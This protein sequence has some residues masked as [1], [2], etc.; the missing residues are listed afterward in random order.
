[1]LRNAIESMMA[2]SLLAVPSLPTE[3]A[4]EARPDPIENARLFG[5]HQLQGDLMHTQ[6]IDLDERR[7]W[8]TSVDSRNS[9]GYLQ[10][11]DRASGKLLRRLDLTDGAR[12][13]PG[14]FS[15]SGNSIWVPVAEYSA[16]TSSVIVEV[17]I[18][19]LTIRR[20]ITIAD[21]LGCAAVTGDTLVAGNWD[22]KQLYVID[23]RGTASP[24]IVPN[25]TNTRYQDMKFVGGQLVASGPTSWSS[26]SIDW[27]DFP[28]LRPVRSLRTWTTGRSSLLPGASLLSR[29]GMALR[30]SDLYLLPEDGPGRLIHYRLD[31]AGNGARGPQL[32]RAAD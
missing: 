4:P 29:E 11:F 20:K 6:G 13:H 27:I 5:I 1:M 28:S 3:A 31:D 24:R 7:I 14:G 12:Y 19:S 23:L 26:G 30:G 2:V 21:H 17:D 16:N 15:I 32:A 8:V 25:P 18:D 9:R 10:E 22:S